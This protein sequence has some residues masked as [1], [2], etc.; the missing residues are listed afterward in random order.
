MAQVAQR[1]CEISN[2]RST[3]KAPSRGPRKLAVDDPPE[4]GLGPDGLQRRGNEFA[5]RDKFLQVMK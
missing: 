4:Q 5:Q 1:R 2:I 3:Q